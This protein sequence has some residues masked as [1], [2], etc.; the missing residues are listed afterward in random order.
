MS[1]YIDNLL[2]IQHQLDDYDQRRTIHK[3][4]LKEI[5]RVKMDDEHAKQRKFH[6][7]MEDMESQ[8]HDA[9][10]SDEQETEGM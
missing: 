5:Q 1:A 3:A 8:G 2:A 9:Y 6:Y 7:D 4:V 10:I